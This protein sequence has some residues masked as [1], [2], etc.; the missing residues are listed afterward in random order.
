MSVPVTTGKDFLTPSEHFM[1]F[2]CK[3]MV[4]YGIFLVLVTRFIFIHETALKT[5]AKM[6]KIFRNF[7]NYLKSTNQQN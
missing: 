7:Y 2:L 6:V 4:K 3:K 5:C 1:L